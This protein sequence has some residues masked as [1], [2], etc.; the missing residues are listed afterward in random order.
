MREIC[1]SKSSPCSGRRCP[2]T[3]KPVAL[4]KRVC[5]FAQKP[6]AASLS[7][8][9][10]LLLA[11]AAAA[12]CLVVPEAAVAGES[13]SPELADAFQSWLVR[14]HRTIPSKISSVQ[15]TRLTIH[16]A[17]HMLQCTFSR[18]HLRQSAT[19]LNERSSIVFHP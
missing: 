14:S 19:P 9:Q 16:D 2:A 11:S 17:A 18:W 15:M 6:G 3:G 12:A 7:S 10:S 8:D 13:I 1:Y 5:C 4:R